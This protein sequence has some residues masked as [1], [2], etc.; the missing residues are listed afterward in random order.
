MSKDIKLLGLSQTVL[1]LAETNISKVAKYGWGRQGLIALWF[2][3][4]DIPT[5][6]FMVYLKSK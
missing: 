4:G 2:G 6:D 1:E 5:P 3:E